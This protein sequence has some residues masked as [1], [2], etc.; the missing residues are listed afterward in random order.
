[1]SQINKSALVPYSAEQMFAIVDDVPAYQEFLPWC[2]G[3]EEVSREGDQVVASVTI[4][5]GSINKTFTTKNI[6]EQPSKIKMELVDGPFKQLHGFWI[7]DELK[8]DACK[9]S[10]KLDY[11]F[12]NRIISMAIGPVFNQVANQMVDSFVQRAH[13]V[14]GKK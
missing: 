7:F 6:N 11:E 9:V 8:A 4:A 13:A 2:G 12:A 5:K 10:L 3:S 1:M 14:Y